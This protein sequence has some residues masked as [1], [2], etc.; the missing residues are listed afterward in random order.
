MVTGT[1]ERLVARPA[2]PRSRRCQAW[3]RWS[4]PPLGPIR[5]EFGRFGRQV[6][7]YSLEHL[8]PERGRRPGPGPGR[9]RGH[10]GRGPRGD[11]PAG[12]GAGGDRRWSCSAT[13]TWPTA[14][15]AVP[16]LLP[17]RPGRRSRASTPA[18]STWSGAA[19]RAVPDLPRGGGWLLVELAG[20]TPAEAEAARRRLI[21]AAGGPTRWTHSRAPTRTRRRPV[22]DPRGRRRARRPQPGRRAG[23]APAGRTRPSRPSASAPTC[24]TSG[25]CWPATG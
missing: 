5:T 19:G 4:G 9:Q 13:R 3:T 1:G 17:H 10:P 24:A 2:A 21:A 8:L 18:S 11:R 14:A 22:A 16:A 7:G 25:P 23:L 20:A 12:R 15:D 6:S